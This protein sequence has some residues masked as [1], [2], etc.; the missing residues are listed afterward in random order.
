[1]ASDI[2][3]ANQN[4]AGQTGDNVVIGGAT[5]TIATDWGS[6]GGTGFSASHVQIVKP[7]WGDTDYSYRVSK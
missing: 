4:V 6:G 1:M 7:S 3:D 2:A 5:Y